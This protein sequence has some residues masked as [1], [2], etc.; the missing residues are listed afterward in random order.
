MARAGRLARNPGPPRRIAH[1]S[2]SNRGRI[3]PGQAGSRG[4]SW[5]TRETVGRRAMQVGPAS[6]H[7]GKPGG[8]S[9]DSRSGGGTKQKHTPAERRKCDFLGFRG[10]FLTDCPLVY[11]LCLILGSW[12]YIANSEGNACPESCAVRFLIGSVWLVSRKLL[13]ISMNSHAIPCSSDEDE[14]TGHQTT[15]RRKQ[16]VSY[17]HLAFIEPRDPARERADIPP[18]GARSRTPRKAGSGGGLISGS[19]STR[20]FS[21][22]GTNERRGGATKGQGIWAAGSEAKATTRW[23]ARAGCR[24]RPLF[25]V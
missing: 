12:P 9:K 20:R 17:R 21:S 11:M 2:G 23:T 7:D 18:G 15:P 24:S 25:A 5:E 10:K 16:K 4:T 8:F 1:T 13:L 19:R 14:D 6:N 3:G 22:G